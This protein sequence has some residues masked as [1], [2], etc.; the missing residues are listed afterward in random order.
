VKENKENIDK[1]EGKHHHGK[2]DNAYVQENKSI[3]K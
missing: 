3:S 2:Q 1:N